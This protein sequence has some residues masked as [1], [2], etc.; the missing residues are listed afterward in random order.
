MMAGQLRDRSA[1]LGF[2]LVEALVVTA[3][4]GFILAIL[5]TVTA[6]W[7][8][9][10]NYGFVRTQRA[11]LVETAIE[12]LAGDISSAE[13]VSPSRD[14]AG[15]LFDGD[16]RS[17]TFVRTAI[18]PNAHSGLEIVRIS[19][20]ADIK[21]T[22]LVRTRAMFAPGAPAAQPQ[23]ADPVVLLRAPFRTSFSYAGKD[24]VW[25][26]EWRGAMQLPAAVRITI[27][28]APGERALAISTVAAV[29]T[30]LPADCV[31]DKGGDVCGDLG[32]PAAKTETA[33]TAEKAS[34]QGLR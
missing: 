1:V 12:R 13:F 6:Q 33:V 2:T 18:G 7:L 4:T 15:P 3:L 30:E 29:R 31:G 34:G 17:I 21:G 32:R 25:K 24:S 26:S 16:E 28:G 9:N 11:E 5:A 19:E 14:A 20:T 27:R 10:W 8:P 22:A 23:F